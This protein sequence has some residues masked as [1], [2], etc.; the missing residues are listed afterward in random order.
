MLII[1][2]LVIILIIIYVNKS[3]SNEFFS[4]IKK[5]NKYDKFYKCS[6]RYSMLIGNCQ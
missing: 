2:L 4:N 6:G 3:D 1:I 5:I